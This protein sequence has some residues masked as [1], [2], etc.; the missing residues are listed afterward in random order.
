MAGSLEANDNP[1]HALQD[2]QPGTSAASNQQAAFLKPP[3]LA[4][5]CSHSV[6]VNLPAARSTRVSMRALF[7]IVL[8]TLTVSQNPP[9][10]LG[11]EEQKVVVRSQSVRS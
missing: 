9:M 8:C 6:A 4:I 7:T 1:D 3:H 5:G 2:K 10:V 11:I